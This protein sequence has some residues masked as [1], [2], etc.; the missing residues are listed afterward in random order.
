MKASSLIILTALICGINSGLE[1]FNEKSCSDYSNFS[2]NKEKQAYSLDFCRTTKLQANT[3]KCCFV[4]FKIDDKTYFG[5]KEITLDEF[6]NV[7]D[8]IGALEAADSKLNIKT[9]DCK[10]NYLYASFLL[11]LF[12]FF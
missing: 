8:K 6:Y 2:T 7:D 4:K 9:F 11:L 1:G 3:N 12:F 5:C 10:S